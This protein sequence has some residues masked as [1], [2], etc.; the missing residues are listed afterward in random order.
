VHCVEQAWE[1]TDLMFRTAGTSAA[2]KDSKLAR[3]YRDLAVL[4][5]HAFLQPGRTAVNF[6]RQQFGFAPASPL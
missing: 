4:R 1:A 6:A 3:H 5:T 2:R